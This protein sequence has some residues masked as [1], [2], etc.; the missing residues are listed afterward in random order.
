MDFTQL[1]VVEAASVLAGPLVGQFFAELGARVIKFEN[2][3]TGGDVTRSWRTTGENARADISA[4]FSCANFGK[5]SIAVNLHLESDTNLLRDAI[6]KADI[7][8][9]NWK[10]G[11]AEKFGFDVESCCALNSKLIYGSISGYGEHNARVGY[12]AIVQAESGLMSVNGEATGGATK[13]PVAMVDIMAAHQ[14]KQGILVA[15]LRRQ[16]T[17]KGGAVHVSLIESAVSSLVNQG[18]NY[19]HTGVVPKR[20]GS[21]HPNIVPYGT[22]FRTKDNEEILLAIGTDAQ[23][24]DVC[25][26]LNI[27]PDPRFATNHERVK[28]RRDVL[29]MLQAA[30]SGVTAD[31][32]LNDCLRANIPAGRVQSVA[33]ALESSYAEPVIIASEG[34][35]G[36]RTKV[37][38]T[39]SNDH[40]S[41]LLRPP[42]LNEHGDKLRREF[43]RV[44]GSAEDDAYESAE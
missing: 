36:I 22:V 35:K 37:F 26:V 11:D 41:V 30:I 9:H 3:Q 17:G 33:T 28:N 13:M 31:M 20:E 44:N 43:G 25:A 2:A 7:F 19:L 40:V 34:I 5:E 8:L 29:T 4:Y 32:F 1:L 39:H 15:L 18:T 14:L 38:H 21:D 12:D 16:S 10:A 24:N 27:T 42:H 23:F 6:S